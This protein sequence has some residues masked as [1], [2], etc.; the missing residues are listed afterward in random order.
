QV[1]DPDVVVHL[2]GQPRVRGELL[3]GEIVRGQVTEALPVLGAQLVGAGDLHLLTPVG[4]VG[5]PG[6]LLPGE[7]DRLGQGVVA[8]PEPHGAHLLGAGATGARVP[9][10]RDGGQGFG[11]GARVVVVAVRGDEGHR[12]GAG[13][14]LCRR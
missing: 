10:G 5:D 13:G 7:G 4:A 14:R 11:A 2:V 1:V 8:T 9:G 12:V 6:V 3:C